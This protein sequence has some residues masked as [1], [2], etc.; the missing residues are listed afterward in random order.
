M[1]VDYQASIQSLQSYVPPET[2][3]QPKP[4]LKK[5]DKDGKKDSNSKKS[6]G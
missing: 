3:P 4:V 5:K 6:P 2:P 1:S